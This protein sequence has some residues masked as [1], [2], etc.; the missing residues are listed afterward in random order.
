V[1]LTKSTDDAVA[2]EATR[3]MSETSRAE[4]P[5]NEELA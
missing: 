2:H 3:I 4:S 1:L 5:D